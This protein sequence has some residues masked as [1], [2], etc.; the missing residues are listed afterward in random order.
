VLFFLLFSLLRNRLQRWR[1]LLHDEALSSSSADEGIDPPSGPD[2]N[3][4]DSITLPPPLQGKIRVQVEVSV[5]I[6][7]LLLIR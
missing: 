4:D 2:E 6:F 3:D 1:E 5:V 7:L